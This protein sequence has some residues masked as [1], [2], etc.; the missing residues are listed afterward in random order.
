VRVAYRP[1]Y[2]PVDAG[3]EISPR[4]AH[5]FFA[6]AG[7]RPVASQHSMA[8]DQ[9]IR[10]Y[11]A[12]AGQTIVEIGVAE[13]S[14]AASMRESMPTDASLYLI[15]PYPSGKIPFLNMTFLVA[16]K[17]VNAVQNGSVI[18][19]KDF[20][21]D[22]I[23]QWDRSLEI[24]LLFIDGDHSEQGCFRDWQDW[25]PLVRVGGYVLF[26]D[27]CLFHGGWPVETDGPVM[28]VNKVFKSQSPTDQ[29]K[30]IE[31]VNSVVV[32]QRQF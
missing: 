18:W 27:A 6:F 24:D 1:F 31:E 21:F 22:A 10:K 29:W 32:V 12:I 25:S 5:S 15:D 17:A 13:G 8:E 28:V 3:Q 19:L 4:L 16:Q 11:A 2:K 14:S 30:I 26:H 20:S 7:L 9:V 23:Q